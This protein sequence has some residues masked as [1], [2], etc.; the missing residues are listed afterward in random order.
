MVFDRFILFYVGL[1]RLSVLSKISDVYASIS[2]SETI[3]ETGGPID[4]GEGD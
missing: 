2:Q 3:L 4:R 1:D